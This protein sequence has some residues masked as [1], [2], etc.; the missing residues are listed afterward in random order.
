MKL[1]LQH[2]IF[3]G[4]I[5]LTAVIGSMAATMLRERSRVHKIEEEITEIREANQ[6]INAATGTLQFLPHWENQPLPGARKT[7]KSIS[8][9]SKKSIASCC[10]CREIT[11]N[12][13]RHL[14]LTHFALY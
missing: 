11:R 12:I 13:L 1:L 10:F 5:I 4:Y 7:F 9:G 3:F 2:R 6:T 14:Q 8:C